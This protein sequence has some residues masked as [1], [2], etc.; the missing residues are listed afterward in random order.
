AAAAELLELAIGLGGDKPWRRLRAAGDQFQAGATD[1][2]RALLEE[3]IDE[4]RPG[5]LRAIAFNLLG[6]MLIY[7]NR[8]V[9]ATKLLGRA[10]EDAR[11][12]AVVLV[13]T[14]MSLSFAQGMGSF[15]EGTSEEGLFDV[16]LDNSWRAV[17]LAE[18]L[19]S[20]TVLSQALAMWVHTV[21]IHGHGVDDSALA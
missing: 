5:M 19:G 16:M 18:E 1:R 3:V 17:T 15:A 13:Q 11:D 6:A 9:E 12:M 7:D 21:F 2:A 10:A 20:A 14:L 8:F 4:L